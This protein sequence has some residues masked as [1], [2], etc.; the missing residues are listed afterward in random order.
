MRILVVFYILCSIYACELLIEKMIVCTYVKGIYLLIAVLIR[1]IAKH[2]R[3]LISL[4]TSNYLSFF[5]YNF[6]RGI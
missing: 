1:Q 2:S 4:N 6:Y 5:E 3:Y